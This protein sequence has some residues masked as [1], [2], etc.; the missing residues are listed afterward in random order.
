MGQEIHDE[1]EVLEMKAYIVHDKNKPLYQV[2]LKNIVD[3]FPSSHK[4]N[5]PL[6][7]LRTAY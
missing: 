4:E 7:G 2:F 6:L 5:L 3:G 1:D